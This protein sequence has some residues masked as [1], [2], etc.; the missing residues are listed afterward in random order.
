M[1]WALLVVLVAALAVAV[2]ALWYRRADL[3]A[4]ERNLAERKRAVDSGSH[5]ARLQYPEVDLSRCIGCGTCI[6]AC[7]ED[8]VL[9][10]V[11]GQAVV[12]HGARCVGHGR[13]AA[14][15]PVGAIALTLGDISDR[16]DIP[17]LTEA[18]E[19]THV[20]GL[21]LAGEVTGYALVRT[22]ITHGVLVA[23]AVSAR[24]RAPIAAARKRPSGAGGV[25]VAEAPVLDLVI[26]GAGPAGIACALQAK[27]HGLSFIVLEQDEIGGTVAKYPRRKLVMTQPV[28]LP[29]HGRLDRTSYSKEELIDLWHRIAREQQLPIRTGEEFVRVDR[30]EDG[31]LL[32]HTRTSV[33]AAGHVCLA[34][35]RRGTPRKLGVPGEELQKVSYSLLDAHS[36]TGR[37]ILVVGG[38][39][40]AIEAALGLSEQPGNRVTISYRSKSFLRLKARNALR[41][42]EAVRAGELEVLYESHVALIAPDRVHLKFDDGTARDV[43]NDDVFVF[44]GGIPPIDVLQK[45]G[46]SFDPTERKAATPLSE[47]GT[48]LFPALSMAL[49]LTV[50]A[51]LWVAWHREYYVLGPAARATHADHAALKPS[52]SIGLWFGI[53]AAL[54]TLFNL[55][56]LLRRTGRF[57]WMRGTLQHWMTSHVVTGILAL[58]LA[59]VHSAMAPQHTVGGHALAALG[60]L[61]VTGGIGRYFYSFV[62]RAAN[63][64]ELALEEVR[65]RLTAITGEWDRG[66]GAFAEH[67]R[68]EV[69]RFVTES[70]WSG[71]FFARVRSLLSSERR[72]RATLEKLRIQGHLEGVAKDHLD[73]LMMLARKA[74]RTALMAAHYEDLRALMAS[75]RYFHRWV[76]LGMVLLVVLHVIAALRYGHLLE[77]MSGS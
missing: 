40:S 15:C 52:G 34:L 55:A 11:H 9:E 41:L 61:I 70:Q 17:V 63:G 54:L 8:G 42:H 43:P 50:T 62:P 25:M 35:G 66:S 36:Y 73:A 51:L 57:A 6:K 20:P 21:F 3:A 7:P 27:V 53:V 23:N 60:I 71:S 26:V 76:A 77:R 30:G 49:A 12:V 22:A 46:V 59:I 38:G 2:L 48:G 29:L 4:T 13:C 58:L 33:V 39:D 47:R 24:T 68:A 44:A 14:E 67:V 65:T 10:L 75:W 56:Y 16:Q 37:K 45:S 31:V 64:R 5:R 1:S 28:E 74:Q 32:V 72:M 18:L 19:S 69:Q